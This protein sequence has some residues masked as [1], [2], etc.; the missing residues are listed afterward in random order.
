[1]GVGR[2]GGGEQSGWTGRSEG[3]DGGIA[4]ERAEA[5][6]RRTEREK[7]SQEAR[8]K[9]KWMG[10]VVGVVGGG[11]WRGREEGKQTSRGC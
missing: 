4:G 9:P 3:F 8:G 1:M 7:V 2:A 11:S 10:V 6:P 5:N